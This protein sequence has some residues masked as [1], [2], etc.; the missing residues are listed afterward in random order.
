MEIGQ[1]PESSYSCDRSEDE[2]W[3]R[4]G[5]PPDAHELDCPHCQAQRQR[6]APLSFAAA[7]WKTNDSS[8]DDE[9]LLGGIRDRVMDGIRAEIRRGAR[10]TLRVTPRGQLRISGHLLLETL[11]EAVDARPG[12]ELRSHKIIPGPRPDSVSLALS[13]ALR[14]GQDGAKVARE[15][16]EAILARFA[17]R[18]GIPLGSI[19]ITL[20]DVTHVN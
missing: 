11:R 15:T 2:L 3:S 20:E 7:Q 1:L 6:L 13:L 12:L 18:I 10:F 14:A 8:V 17:E 9:A 4:M 16:R 5:F 19:D